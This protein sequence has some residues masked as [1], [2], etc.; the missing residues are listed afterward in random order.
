VTEIAN[1]HDA[2]VA[3]EDTRP[4]QS[5]PGARFSVRF[6]AEPGGAGPA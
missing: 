6:A 5:P 1:L 4:G 2:T 3:M